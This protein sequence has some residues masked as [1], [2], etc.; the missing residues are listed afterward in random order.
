MTRALSVRWPR[1]GCIG[2][3]LAS[4]WPVRA[5]FMVD[6]W[7][8]ASAHQVFIDQAMNVLKDGSPA[9]GE[10]ACV[11]VY[12]WLVISTC[13][14]PYVQAMDVLKV[15]SDGGLSLNAE[16]TGGELKV[17]NAAVTPVLAGRSMAETAPAG[18]PHCRVRHRELH[19]SKHQAMP[20]V[21]SF[22]G[23]G[24][25]AGSCKIL[26]QNSASPSC[27]LACLQCQTLH[28]MCRKMLQV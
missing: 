16:I 15:V 26:K 27:D 24:H 8:S 4:C 10:C 25:L 19:C 20:Q 28:L 18:G 13:S 12:T 21:R 9:A 3:W 6:T 1:D 22:Q 5:G 17:M 11:V 2:G 14:I 23:I 7:L